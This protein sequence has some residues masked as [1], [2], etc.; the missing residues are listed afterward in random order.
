MPYNI[1]D[2]RGNKIGQVTSAAE[3]AAGAALMIIFIIYALPYI[4]AIGLAIL[5]FSGLT[6]VYWPWAK[7]AHHLTQYENLNGVI[8]CLAIPLM[9]FLISAQWEKVAKGEVGIVGE[10]GRIAAIVYGVIAVVSIIPMLSSEHESFAA[11]SGKWFL[12][13]PVAVSTLTYLRFKPIRIIVGILVGIPLAIVGL[14]IA[15]LFIWAIVNAIGS[16]LFR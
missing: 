15:I 7:T 10:F 13:A 16:W 6:Q 14:G 4:L 1:Y 5:A 11:I 12:I 9:A 3:E 8:T 2:N